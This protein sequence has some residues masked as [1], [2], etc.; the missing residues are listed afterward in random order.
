MPGR[1]GWPE[2]LTPRELE[3]LK[4]VAEG[5][6]N[7]EIGERLFISR[8]TVRIHV[9]RILGKLGASNRI[10]AVRQAQKLGMIPPS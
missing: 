10:E 3:I 8:G 9:S 6:T 4:L 2:H 1:A 5:L 7:P